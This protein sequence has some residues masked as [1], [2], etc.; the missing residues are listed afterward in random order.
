MTEFPVTP[1]LKKKTEVTYLEV[2]IE[3]K[4]LNQKNTPC[5]KEKTHPMSKKK[6]RN[7]DQLNIIK[8]LMSALDNK[9]PSTLFK[10][11]LIST[12]IWASPIKIISF[13]S[14]R[15]YI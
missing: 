4:S 9:A 11:L 10:I 15:I 2:K 3:K 5:V 7:L 14:Y 12:L 6:P 13:S 8:K 1:Y